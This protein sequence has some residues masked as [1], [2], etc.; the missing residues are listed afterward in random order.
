[1]RRCSWG[2]QTKSIRLQLT[3]LFFLNLLCLMELLFG[4]QIIIG[5]HYMCLRCRTLKG[6]DVTRLTK[7]MLHTVEALDSIF[8]ERERK[9]ETDGQRQREAETQK[10]WLTRVLTFC[11]AVEQSVP[12]IVSLPSSLFLS[13]TYI[14]VPYKWIWLISFYKVHMRQ[15]IWLK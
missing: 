2:D 14:H 10:S 4:T 9:R 11:S 15:G 6:Q 7:H 13:H 8:T 12:L 5:T 3:W 1:M